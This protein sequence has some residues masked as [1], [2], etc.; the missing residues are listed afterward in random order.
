MAQVFGQE[1]ALE[2]FQVQSP[3]QLL[4]VLGVLE[5]WALAEFLAPRQCFWGTK[6]AL[7]AF[8]GAFGGMAGAGFSGA[9]I[10][11]GA[12]WGAATGAAFTGVAISPVGQ[13]IGRGIGRTG[14]GRFLNSVNNWVGSSYNDFMNQ[15]HGGEMLGGTP[16]TFGDTDEVWHA[17]TGESADDIISSGRTLKKPFY[18]FN[19]NE[20]V[21][22]V[23][24]RD[25]SYK[26]LQKALVIDG[27]EINSIVR[28]PRNS[29]ILAP[30]PNGPTTG[31][32]GTGASQAIIYGNP[33]T[34]VPLRGVTQRPSQI[35]ITV[36]DETGC[37]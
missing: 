17:T 26:Q 33:G 10:G 32:N 2:C 15:V 16:G 1:L 14:F 23:K 5:Q 3:E 34:A 24:L 13:A 28:I 6:L 8:S 22:G 12:M 31:P 36:C 4:A 21:E 19:P 7:G 20:E 11:Q 35:R 30:A 25:M 29:V 27:K 37:S 18:V 9:S